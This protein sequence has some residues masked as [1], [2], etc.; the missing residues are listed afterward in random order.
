MVWDL[1]ASA[2]KNYKERSL[3]VKSHAAVMGLLHTCMG[4]R[5]PAYLGET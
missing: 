3:E 5:L 2:R 1:G 4:I